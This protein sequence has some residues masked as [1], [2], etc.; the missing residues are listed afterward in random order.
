MNRS[1]LIEFLNFKV[2]QYNTSAFIDQDPVLIP[3]MFSKK[4]DIEISGFLTALLSWGNRKAIQ[5]AATQ[6]MELMDHSPYNFIIEAG[7]HELKTLK[8]YYYRTFQPGDIEFYILS[9][10]NIYKNHSGLEHVFTFGYTFN[11]SAFESIE[12]ARNLFF[13]I[14]HNQRHMKHFSSPASGSAAKRLNMF[15]RWMC[16]QDKMQVDFGIWNNISQKDLMCPLD[17]HSGN[18]S[19]KLGLLTRM[20]N[21]RKAVEELT[22]VLRELDPDDPVKYD[23]ALFGLGVFEKF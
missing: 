22:R 20:Q 23:F 9:L 19:R 13:E 10:N 7:H 4:E 5:K 16:R 3:H 11:Q 6:L 2:E 17:V 8:K 21:D 14:P 1:E 18:V 12:Y 15:L